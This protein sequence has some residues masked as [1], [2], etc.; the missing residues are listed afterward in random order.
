MYVAG[1]GELAL[2]GVPERIVS[3][4]SGKIFQRVD[5]LALVTRV[6]RQSF[7]GPFGERFVAIVIV[8]VAGKIETHFTP[9]D[10]LIQKLFDRRAHAPPALAAAARAVGKFG[11]R[12]FFAGH[13]IVK[14]LVR[15]N[16]AEME[17]GRKT[18][19][20]FRGGLVA[21]LGV[22]VDFLG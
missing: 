12:P 5:P 3:A 7:L 17:I 19:G 9:G 11:V 1:G 2:R 20:T 21:L 10:E 6:F 15:G 14:H 18:G 8:A 13:Q 4:S 22:L 16:V